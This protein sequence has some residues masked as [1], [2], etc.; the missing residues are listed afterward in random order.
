MKSSAAKSPKVY[1][2]LAPKS[3]PLIKK[4]IFMEPACLATRRAWPP[5][6][7]HAAA[8]A[9]DKPYAHKLCLKLLISA[10]DNY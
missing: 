6:H 10:I 9:N 4:E 1:R 5:R 8:I 3:N 2:L 7:F